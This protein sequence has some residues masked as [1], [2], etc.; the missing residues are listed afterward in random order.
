MFAYCGNNPVI[1]EDP[2]EYRFDITGGRDNGKYISMAIQSQYPA[3]AKNVK[4]RKPKPQ[5][6]PSEDTKKRDALISGGER[7]LSE[8]EKVPEQIPIVQN[9]AI[10]RGQQMPF[11]IPVKGSG[12]IRS[13][14]K[15]GSAGVVGNILS[16]IAILGNFNSRDGFRVGLARTTVDLIG[17][18]AT[19]ALCTAL[20]PEAATVGTAA[21]ITVGVSYGVSFV[22][23]LIKDTFYI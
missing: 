16:G 23:D 4:K 9:R 19:A 2:N 18:A 7:V 5:P 21:A 14:G 12:I 17:M 1:M 10:L 15:I 3:I 20:I 22:S 11:N 8:L 6:K 13:V